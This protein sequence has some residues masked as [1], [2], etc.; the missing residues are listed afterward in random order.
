MKKVLVTSKLPGEYLNWLSTKCDLTVYDGPNKF[1]SY[2][3][4]LAVVHTYDGLLTFVT[5][6]IDKTIIDAG[7]KLKVISNYAV[8]YNNIDV[9]YCTKRGI[10]VCNT[11]GVLTETTADCAFALLL[12]TARRI[13]EAD[14]YV[15][16][17]KFTGWQPDLF[18]GLDV[19]G[20]TLGIIGMGRIGKAV[21]K[22][23]SGFNMRVIYYDY[24]QD[25]QNKQATKVS[26]EQVLT[27]SDFISLHV[28]YLQSTHHLIDENALKSMK[29]SAILI[30]TARGPVVDE[31]ALA[32]ALKNGTIAGAGLDVF[33]KEP[34]VYEDLLN[35]NNAILLPHIGSSSLATRHKMVE[36]A[37]KNLWQVINNKP[38]LHAV[39]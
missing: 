3:E 22:R 2:S 9:E 24:S 13:V 4:L 21:S 25:K 27:E 32:L 23:A 15:R 30:N 1:M 38:P 6:K 7:K 31:K 36:L 28:P 14:K 33:E 39:N 34:T 11:P 19:Y 26:L 17:K 5:N 29:S 8:G 16:D 10:K 37:V 20:K 18:M 12:A 35:L